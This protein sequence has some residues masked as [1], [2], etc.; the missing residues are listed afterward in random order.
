MS[1]KEI[2]IQS[3]KILFNMTMLI[4]AKGF[5][6]VPGVK[7]LAAVYGISQSGFIR[8]VKKRFGRSPG[9]ILRQ[10][11]FL[12]AVQ[13]VQQHHEPDAGELAQKLGYPDSKSLYQVL[14]Y[15]LDMSTGAFIDAVREQ[16]DEITMTIIEMYD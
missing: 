10:L 5:S 3:E 7:E 2:Q 9:K 14:S 16:P 12:Q 6:K 1:L 4:R 15:H 13:Y 11:K 8:S